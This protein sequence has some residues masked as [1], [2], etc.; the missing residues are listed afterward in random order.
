MYVHCIF[1]HLY[2]ACFICNIEITIGKVKQCVMDPDP[3]RELGKRIRAIKLV[4]TENLR[5][6][7]QNLL[8]K[9]K[10]CH[11]FNKDLY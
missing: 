7:Q 4:E 5:L 11:F 10:K 6:D 9:R 3:Y 1:K 8:F 2:L